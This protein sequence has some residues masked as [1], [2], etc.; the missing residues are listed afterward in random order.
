[1]TLSSLCRKHDE[2]TEGGNCGDD[3]HALVLDRPRLCGDLF[4]FSDESLVG[5]RYSGTSVL[6]YFL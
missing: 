5:P 4:A 2:H 6:R 3:L 1:M